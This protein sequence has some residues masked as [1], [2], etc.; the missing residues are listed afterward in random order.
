VTSSAEAVLSVPNSSNLW[1]IRASVRNSAEP[2]VLPAGSLSAMQGRCWPR[3]VRTA[4]KRPPTFS[5]I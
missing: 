2:S 1:Q 5:N 4:T 3:A